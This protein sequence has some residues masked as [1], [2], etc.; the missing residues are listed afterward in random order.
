MPPGRVE[1]SVGSHHVE[2]RNRLSGNCISSASLQANAKGLTHQIGQSICP[3]LG[4]ESLVW[5]RRGTANDGTGVACNRIGRA[6]RRFDGKTIG[7]AQSLHC[8][9][10]VRREPTVQTE[11][12]GRKSDTSLTQHGLT[13]R[14][15][16]R[17][18]G[19]CPVLSRGIRGTRR[20]SCRNSSSLDRLDSR[21]VISGN[22]GSQR[23]QFRLTVPRS[24]GEFSQA[25]DFLVNLLMK[26]GIAASFQRLVDKPIVVNYIQCVSKASY[27][28]ETARS[29]V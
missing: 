15:L 2:C 28:F 8:N 19:G 6:D 13:A 12:V 29:L 10:A 4:N 26:E 23:P 27:G 18:F 20:T 14:S 22:S 16:C 25:L 7:G 11:Q 1:R 9:S 17:P 5:A 3:D 21:D 24:A